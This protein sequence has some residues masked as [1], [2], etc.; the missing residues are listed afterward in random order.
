MRLISKLWVVALI[1]IILFFDNQVR[2]ISIIVGII[3]FSIGGDKGFVRS[4]CHTYLI[5][6]LARVI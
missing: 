4:Q 6:L 3:N 5:L 1:Q 2:G